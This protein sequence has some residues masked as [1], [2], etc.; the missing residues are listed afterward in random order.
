MIVK[1][2]LKENLMSEIH[3]LTLCWMRRAS[4]GDPDAEVNKK[5]MSLS[6]PDNRMVGATSWLRKPA[7]EDIHM[8]V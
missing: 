8:C 3:S 4:H 1:E 6:W 7:T 5:L 2:T